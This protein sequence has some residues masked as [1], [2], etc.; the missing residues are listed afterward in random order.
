MVLI[1]IILY[2]INRQN[3]TIACGW[4]LLLAFLS[5]VKIGTLLLMLVFAFQIQSHENNHN[6]AYIGLGAGFAQVLV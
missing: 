5:I 3:F 6:Y 1:Y 2:C 4:W